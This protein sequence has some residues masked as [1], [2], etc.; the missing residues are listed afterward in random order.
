MRHVESDEEVYRLWDEL[1]DFGA[2]A[3]DEAAKYCMRRLCTW[4]DADNAFWI[5][6]IRLTSGAQARNDPMLGWRIGTINILDPSHVGGRQM[7]DGTLDTRSSDPGPTSRAM[8]SGAGR[9][10]VYRLLD[11]KLVD[12]NA[13]RN[14]A[15]YD[16]FYRKRGISDRIWAAFPVNDDTESYFCFDKYG[17]GRIFSE[18]D[19]N[20]VAQALRGI[21]WFHR[22]LLLSHGLHV[23]EEVLT[24]SE[25]RMLH[26]LLSGASEREIAARLHLTPGTVHQYTVRI[27]RKFGVSGRAEFMSLWLTGFPRSG[28][29]NHY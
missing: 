27:F 14:T 24:R 25:R 6:A 2:Q 7:R 9:F 4:I 10:R 26:E 19:L 16:R 20:L 22:H 8:A 21:K 13:F 28:N 12:L 5:G 1:C 29:K 11:G 17:E 15:H 23:S 3:S 18:D